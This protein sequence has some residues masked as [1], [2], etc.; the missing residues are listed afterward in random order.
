MAE[1]LTQAPGA[2]LAL[3][4]SNSAPKG[5]LETRGKAEMNILHIPLN[6]TVSMETG[7]ANK[8]SKVVLGAGRAGQGFVSMPEIQLIPTLG[9]MYCCFVFC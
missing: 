6:L 3:R 8:G 1:S 5:L 2:P 7:S 9:F 4:T